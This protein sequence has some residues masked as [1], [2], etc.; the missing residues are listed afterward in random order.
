MGKDHPKLPIGSTIGRFK[1]MKHIGAGGFGEI[2]SVLDTS[3]SKMC[4]MKIEALNQRRSSLK[5]EIE[6]LKEVK[7]SKYF[8]ELLDYGKTHSIRYYVMELL[9][10]SLQN[11][12]HVSP[13]KK[14]SIYTT[15]RIALESLK[16]IEVLHQH[17]W[18]HRDIKPGNFL[19]RDDKNY[20]ICL[21]DFGLCRRYIDKKTGSII[22]PREEPGFTGTCRYASVNA[23]NYKELSRRD[24]IISWIYTF[25]E[26]CDGKL[27]WPGT[28]DREKT[29]EIKKTI[30]ATQLMQTFSDNVLEI[31]RDAR[32]LRFEDEPNYQM[33]KDLLKQA[34]DEEHPRRTGFD[35]EYY[36]KEIVKEVM[37][38]LAVGQP[39]QASQASLSSTKAILGPP[40][41]PFVMPTYIPPVYKPSFMTNL[42]P[43]QKQEQPKPVVPNYAPPNFSIPQQQPAKA[44]PVTP[45]KTNY[46]PT[47]PGTPASYQQSA[48]ETP[49]KSVKNFDKNEDSDDSEEEEQKEDVGCQCRI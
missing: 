46:P 6:I 28:K 17:G 13:H 43:E 33:Y 38:N 44:P 24:D 39:K 27:P 7:G 41:K 42:Q 5:L 34:M 18:V 4:A 14:F 11:M 32:K 29:K 15:L 8:P 20:P 3:T 12:R 25:V 16:A 2:Y 40:R 49:A 26:L 45:I 1:I 10:A 31:Y 36:N 37:P 48:P 47:A 30:S 19:I 23:H 21:I 9:G 22:P 35:W